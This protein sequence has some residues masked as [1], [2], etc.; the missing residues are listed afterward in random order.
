MHEDEGSVSVAVSVLTGT[1]GREVI[2][3]L[4]TLNGTAVGM[5]PEILQKFH[6]HLNIVEVLS[7]PQSSWDGLFQYITRLDIQSFLNNPNCYGV[8]S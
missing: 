2:V 5:S 8:H 3:S 1:L 7:Y 6:I 4:M